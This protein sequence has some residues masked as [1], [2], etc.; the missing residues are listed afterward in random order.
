MA[1]PNR[2]RQAACAGKVGYET[3]G[4]ALA[5]IERAERLRRSTR[6][7]AYRCKEC[8]AWHYGRGGVH[9]GKPED[10]K[11]WKNWHWRTAE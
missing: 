1:N 6:L 11:R 8:G 5:A 2:Y 10:P 7:C 3:H 4:Q 9:F